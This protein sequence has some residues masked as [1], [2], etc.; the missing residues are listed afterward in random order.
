LN[1][2]FVHGETPAFAVASASATFCTCRISAVESLRRVVLVCTSLLLCRASILPSN[3]R[4]FKSLSHNRNQ[5]NT[6]FSSYSHVTHRLVSSKKHQHQQIDPKPRGT[7]QSYNQ[8]PQA[9]TRTRAS[10]PEHKVPKPL[11]II[12]SREPGPHSQD[13]G[14]FM[15]DQPTRR[16]RNS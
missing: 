2:A 11:Q 13:R 16:A 1:I 12:Q 15:H 7:A 14:G 5:V 4:Y 8:T 6:D 3:S 9:A 10:L